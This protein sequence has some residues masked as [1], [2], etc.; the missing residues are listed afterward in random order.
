[1][2]GHQTRP[3]MRWWDTIVLS[4]R[5][6]HCCPGVG[7]ESR[8]H[9]T[10]LSGPWSPGAGVRVFCVCVCVRVRV[11]V[12]CCVCVMEP[13][14]LPGGVVVSCSRFIDKEFV[15]TLGNNACWPYVVLTFRKLLVLFF[16]PMPN[17]SHPPREDLF[18][19]VH[20]I[21]DSPNTKTFSMG[22]YFLLCEVICPANSMHVSPT[23][24]NTPF[25]PT[26]RD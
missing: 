16:L 25:H 10:G 26:K 4:G 1:M 7:S 8:S 13:R 24:L 22:D 17:G 9:G 2:H 20:V 21:S 3:Y 23:L 15:W 18:Q 19:I 14:D 5:A 6:G 12:V 11:Y